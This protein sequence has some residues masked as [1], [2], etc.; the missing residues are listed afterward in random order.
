MWVSTSCII[1]GRTSTATTATTRRHQ[2]ARPPSTEQCLIS[3][4]LETVI[5]NVGVN[6]VHHHWPDIYSHHRHLSA[7]PNS[8]PTKHRCLISVALE[9]V[10]YNVGVNIVHHHWPDINSHHRHH[11]ATPNSSPTKHR[12]TSLC[13]ASK[14]LSSS[15]SV[16][17][18][19]H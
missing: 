19:W 7:T 18:Q 2:I 12:V 11:S 15:D 17:Y 16:S 9:T 6:I 10:I 8:S 14:P 1:T 3:V 5:Y 13:T 4:A